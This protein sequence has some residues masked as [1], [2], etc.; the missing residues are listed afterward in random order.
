ME[1]F[2]LRW[3]KVFSRG[4]LGR[5]P[6][7]DVPYGYASVVTLPAALREKH[8]EPSHKIREVKP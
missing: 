5:V 6:P 2:Y 8:F 3:L 7:C 1:V 4:V